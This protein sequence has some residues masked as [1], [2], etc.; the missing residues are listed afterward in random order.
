MKSNMKIVLA[1]LALSAFGLMMVGAADVQH[2]TVLSGVVESTV[3]PGTAV[4]E[5]DSLVMVETLAGPV[6]AVRATVDGTVK[7]VSVNAGESISQ[8]QV[9]A[10]IASK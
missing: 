8:G 6:P 3:V 1:A 5:G 4:K 9:V 2:E 7:T 10:V